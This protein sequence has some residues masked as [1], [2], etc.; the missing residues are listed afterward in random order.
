[1]RRT[2]GTVNAAVIA[3]GPDAA[4]QLRSLHEWLTDVAEL[5]GRVHFEQS[6]PAPGAMGPALDALA[7]AL[8]P[9]GAATAFA[10]AV[11]AWLRSRRGDVRITVRLP[12]GASAELTAKRVADLDAAALQRQV[13]QI[14]G[15]LEPGEDGAAR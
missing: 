15:L 10:T 11:L 4:D 8:G 9:G 7:I 14:A 6:P 5:R 12:N 13:D 2:G 1:M 3:D